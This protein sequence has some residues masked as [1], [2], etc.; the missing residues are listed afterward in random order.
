VRTMVLRIV[1][2]AHRR[3]HLRNVQPLIRRQNLTTNRC[4]W[5]DFPLE[6][7]R[8][9]SPQRAPAHTARATA[10]TWSLLHDPPRLRSPSHSP[11]LRSRRAPARQPL[12]GRGR[13]ARDCV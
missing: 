8:P 7:R 3:A 2:E 9:N 10:R 6:R 4:R 11:S 5:H 1:N 12:F 13:A